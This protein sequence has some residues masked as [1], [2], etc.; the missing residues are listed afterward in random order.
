[1]NTV[2]VQLSHKPHILVSTRINGCLD[3]LPK[4]VNLHGCYLQTSSYIQCTRA[5][6]WSS[7]CSLQ[8][9]HSAHCLTS[10]T[11][12]GSWE[13]FIYWRW[14]KFLILVLFCSTQWKQ[15][16]NKIEEKGKIQCSADW[17][18]PKHLTRWHRITYWPENPITFNM[19]FSG[20][21]INPISHV[22]NACSRSKADAR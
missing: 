17:D 1:M 9:W 4:G 18:V 21:Q 2:W 15:G 16:C 14:T 13:K 6:E 19:H 3:S 11:I 10:S 20:L 22:L 12:G 8:S 5:P 7:N